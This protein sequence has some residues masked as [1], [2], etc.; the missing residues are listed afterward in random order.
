MPEK[1]PTHARCGDV[2]RNRTTGVIY[3]VRDH[4]EQI[5]S[6]TD[7]RSGMQIDI[8]RPTDPAGY[9]LLVRKGEWENR[10]CW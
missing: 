2:I 10:P 5:L 1:T 9:V 3:F 6:L 4:T 8:T 7:L